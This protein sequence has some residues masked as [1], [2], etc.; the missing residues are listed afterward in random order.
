MRANDFSQ[1]VALLSGMHVL[2][3]AEGIA[4]WLEAKSEEDII[5]LSEVELGHALDF[6]P[7]GSCAYLKADDTVERARE[8]FANDIGKRVFSALVTES[9]SPKQRPFCRPIGSGKRRLVA[10]H[11]LSGHSLHATA[12]VN[13][14]SGH[15]DIPS[16]RWPFT[17]SAAVVIVRFN[18][19]EPVLLILA[20]ARECRNG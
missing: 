14:Q 7:E 19:R 1:I 13:A 8:V 16:P 9:G 2:L 11:T 4:Y 10:A 12:T 15:S 17:A 5:A 18:T 20:F 6:E 3:S